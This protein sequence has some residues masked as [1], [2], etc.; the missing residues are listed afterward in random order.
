MGHPNI[1]SMKLSSEGKIN[2]IPGGFLFKTT[3]CVN[4]G[5]SGSPILNRNGEL[6]A[7]AAFNTYGNLLNHVDREYDYRLDS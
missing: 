5:H 7:I 4:K 1:L 6:V 2:M 3:L